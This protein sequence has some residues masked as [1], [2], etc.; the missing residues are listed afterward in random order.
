MSD[1]LVAEAASYTTDNKYK[2]RTSMP[3]AGCKPAIPAIERLKTYALDLTG[4]I[5]GK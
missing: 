2:R 5:I 4:T 1:Q 3:S